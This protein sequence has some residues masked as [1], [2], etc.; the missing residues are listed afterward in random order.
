MTS[1]TSRNHLLDYLEKHATSLTALTDQISSSF[2]ASLLTVAAGS[3][4]EGFGNAESDIDLMVVVDSGQVTDFP[5]SSHAIG[6][7]VDVNYLQAGWVTQ[8]AGRISSGAGVHEAQRDRAS[9]KAGYRE[10][11][12]LGRIATGDV[13][14]AH[15]DWL[16][17]HHD[18]TSVFPSFARQWWRAEALRQRTAARLLAPTRPLTAAHRYCDAQLA[19]LEGS[20]VEAGQ[21]YVG[22]KW[23]AAKLERL[24]DG[25]LTA[26]FWDAVATPL[27]V[28]EFARYQMRAESALADLTEGDPLP[29]E[30]RLRLTPGTGLRTEQVGA[31]RLV[32]RH[33]IRGLAFTADSPLAALTFEGT[34][35]EG[36]ESDLPDDMRLLACEDLAW[37][38][39]EVI[40]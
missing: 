4:V 40:A 19:A 31:H 17:R 28:D 3:V 16:Q 11:T 37:L 39:L 7:P 34:I 10:L 6:V 22:P 14:H 20:A 32:H 26:A 23:L 38:S 33:G 35:W 15:G 5:V 24:G 18:L 8:A 21:L 29:R 36:P 2:G 27:S 13:L 30:A 12:R 25:R 1:L 9:W